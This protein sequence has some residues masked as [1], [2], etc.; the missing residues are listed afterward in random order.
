MS[1]DQRMEDMLTMEEEG[2][3]EPLAAAE[4]QPAL[5]RARGGRGRA[6]ARLIG[7]SVALSALAALVANVLANS[8][9][10]RRRSPLILIRPQVTNFAPTLTIGVPFLAFDSRRR[11][12]RNRNARPRRAQWRRRMVRRGA[13]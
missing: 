11:M 3:R 2:A 7:T 5:E 10:P 12:P 8:S 13:R 6:I 4:R 1:A 9:A